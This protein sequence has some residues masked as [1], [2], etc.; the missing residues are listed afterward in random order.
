MSEVVYRLWIPRWRPATLNQ[1]MRGHWARGAA[2]KKADRQMVGT[3]AHYAGIPKATGKRR[4][5]VE[6]VLG[7]RH[8]PCDE[9]AFAKSLRDACVCAGLLVDDCT[10]WLEPGPVTQRRPAKGE[11]WGTLITLEDV[12]AA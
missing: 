3:Y 4:L 8:R 1:I 5:T 7:P 2:M 6:V 10:K 12:E 11:E 9:D